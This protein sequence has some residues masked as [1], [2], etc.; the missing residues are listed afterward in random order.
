MHLD[1]KDSTVSSRL[2]QSRDWEPEATKIIRDNLA[3]GQTFVDCGAHIGYFSLLASRIVGPSGLVVAFEPWPINFQYLVAN[4]GL[5]SVRNVVPIMMPLWESNALLSINQSNE[6]TGDVRVSENLG[7]YPAMTLDRL[8]AP[9]TVDFLKIDCQGAD[10]KILRGGKNLIIN[11]QKMKLLVEDGGN[12]PT[13]F[14]FKLVRH[15]QQ[16]QTYYF[17][18]GD[19]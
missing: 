12:V 4:L 17:V 9:N 14:G 6:N 5:N 16:E 19:V 3:E 10:Q 2:S 18:K 7:D 8:F 11:S 13:E 1:S 15:I